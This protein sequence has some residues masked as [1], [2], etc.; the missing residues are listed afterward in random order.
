MDAL[1]QLTNLI[2]DEIAAS[3]EDLRTDRALQVASS[4]VELCGY[5]MARTGTVKSSTRLF[6]LANE[7]ERLRRAEQQAKGTDTNVVQFAQRPDLQWATA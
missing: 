6:L 2:A 7:I 1:E 5:E 3:D 4:L